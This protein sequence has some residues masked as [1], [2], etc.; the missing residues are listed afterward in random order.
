MPIRRTSMKKQI[1]GTPEPNGKEEEIPA[2]EKRISKR[3]STRLSK[4]VKKPANPF[5]TGV[6]GINPKVIILDNNK[7]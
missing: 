6:P 2:S 4:M 5:F 7:K 3:K 1:D